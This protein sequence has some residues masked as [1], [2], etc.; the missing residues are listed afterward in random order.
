M[1]TSNPSMKSTLSFTLIFVILVAA[2]I[3]LAGCSSRDEQ[4]LGT[5]RRDTH[6]PTVIFELNLLRN[7]SGA[8]CLIL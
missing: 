1:P 2:V 7:G 4:L 8:T 5:W 6:I 3:A